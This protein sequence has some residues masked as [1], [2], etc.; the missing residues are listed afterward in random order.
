MIHH[1]MVT[2]AE[3]EVRPP[4][5]DA[6]MVQH[7]LYDGECMDKF[8]GTSL[9]LSFTNWKMPLDWNDT[10]EIDQQIFLLESVIAVQ[11]KGQW[12]ADL[13]VL[14]LERNDVEIMQFTCQCQRGKLVPSMEDVASLDSWEELL[15][16]PPSVGVVRASGNWVARLAAA[17]VLVQKGQ[18]HCLTL[19]VDEPICWECTVEHYA[20]PEPHLPQ[21]IIH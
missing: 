10:G 17:S 7:R 8:Q 14:G 5:Y 4:G 1:R 2:P 19:M 21:F 13:D 11:D 16:S 20:D 15:D 6:Q 12:V 18:S 3:P 9:H